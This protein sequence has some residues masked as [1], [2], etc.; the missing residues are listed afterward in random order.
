MTK[1]E[2][3]IA[4]EMIDKCIWHVKNRRDAPNYND[5]YKRCAKDIL[6]ALEAGRSRVERG[7]PFD[8]T[9]EAF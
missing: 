9:S 7:E 8:S 6:I 1:K 5:A 3:K 2:T 4:L